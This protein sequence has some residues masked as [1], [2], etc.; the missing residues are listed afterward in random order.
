MSCFMAL[1]SDLTQEDIPSGRK[2]SAKLKQLFI[3][4]RRL[5][6]TQAVYH[7]GER[8]KDLID[9]L[10]MQKILDCSVLPFEQ[11]EQIFKME[12]IQLLRWEKWNSLIQLGRFDCVS[13][14]EFNPKA[15]FIISCILWEWELNGLTKFL[16]GY[17][18]CPTDTS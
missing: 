3:E 1:D 11:V 16:Q 17:L 10:D 9:A 18:F 12:W 5:R 14:N 7:K 6:R 2:G 4:Q 13:K 8:A 15:D